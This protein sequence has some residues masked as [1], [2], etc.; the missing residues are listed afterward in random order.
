MPLGSLPLWKLRSWDSSVQI[1]SQA[2]ATNT[3]T[4]TTTTTTATPTPTN[5]PAYT[6]G[7]GYDITILRVLSRSAA[8]LSKTQ[9]WKEICKARGID[10]NEKGSAGKKRRFEEWLPELE[11]DGKIH[12]QTGQ[13]TLLNSLKSFIIQPTGLRRFVDVVS[14]EG[15]TNQ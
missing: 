13:Y 10:V 4:T 11:K 1:T 5:I 6:P 2:Q 9:L 3:T 12:S 15:S 14:M 7:E 8:P